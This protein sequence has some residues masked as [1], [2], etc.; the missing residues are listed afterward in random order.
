ME[1]RALLVGRR[2]IIPIVLLTPSV[3]ED[4]MESSSMTCLTAQLTG[5]LVNDTL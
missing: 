2:W 3:M 4:L 1:H 5:S